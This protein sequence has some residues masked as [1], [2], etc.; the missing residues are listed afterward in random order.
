MRYANPSPYLSTVVSSGTNIRATNGSIRFYPTN[1]ATSVYK[2][3]RSVDTTMV[4][5]SIFNKIKFRSRINAVYEPPV[6]MVFGMRIVTNK[7]SLVLW[8]A[9]TSDPKA[10]YVVPRKVFNVTDIYNGDIND[11]VV[12]Y[13]EVYNDTGTDVE[14][15]Y[16]PDSVVRWSIDLP[17][18]I[19][20]SSQYLAPISYDTTNVPIQTNITVNSNQRV[21]WFVAS[22]PYMHEPDLDGFSIETQMQMSFQTEGRLVVSL[23]ANVD[24][25]I[26]IIGKSNTSQLTSFVYVDVRVAQ[27]PQLAPPAGEVVAVI[28]YIAF[29]Y[30]VRQ[31]APYTGQLTW[32]ISPT[33]A[34]LSIN[35]YGVIVIVPRKA[36][37]ETVTVTATNI[38]GVSSSVN[39][40]L[41]V[42]QQPSLVKIPEIRQ[43]IFDTTTIE[44]QETALDNRGALT[45][46]LTY[47]SPAISY[48]ANTGIITVQNNSF[49]DEVVTIKAINAAGGSNEH[50]FPMKIAQAPFINETS[51][52]I[53]NTEGLIYTKQLSQSAI[54]TG[55]LTWSLAT[56]QRGISISPNGLLTVSLANGYVTT[57]IVAVVSNTIGDAF[58][59]DSR[60]IQLRIGQKPI[61]SIPPPSAVTKSLA[62]GE[63]F[64]Y[65]MVNTAPSTGTLTWTLAR[66][67]TNLTLDPLTGVLYFP[68]SATNFVYETVQVTA[69]N[70][71]GLSTTI[72]FFVN[73]QKTPVFTAHPSIFS[74]NSDNGT[75]ELIRT[76]EKGTPTTVDF[77]QAVSNRASIDMQAAT[78]NISPRPV[79]I[80]LTNSVLTLFNDNFILQLMTLEVKNSAGGVG[81]I[82]FT[83]KVSQ[84]AEV[85]NPG[86]LVRSLTTSSFTHQ[87]RQSAVGTGPLEW[88]IMNAPNGVSINALTGLLTVAK[89]TFV[90]RVITVYTVDTN[91]GDLRLSIFYLLVAQTPSLVNPGAIVSIM[92]EGTPFTYPFKEAHFDDI[93]DN[94]GTGDGL[95][96]SI[97][98]YRSLTISNNGVITLGN[99]NNINDP[100]MTV[101]VMNRAGGMASVTFY[102]NIT[103]QVPLQSFD[104]IVYSM[105]YKTNFTLSLAGSI[106]GAAQ[107]SLTANPGQT[108]IP[109][110]V[111]TLSNSGLLTIQYN[112]YI[113]HRFVLTITQ[114]AAGESVVTTL[115]VYIL[116][117]QTPVLAFPYTIKRISLTNQQS[118][119][120]D[121]SALQRAS[122]TGPITW[123]IRPKISYMDL[124]PNGTLTISGDIDYVNASFTIY[125]INDAGG[126]SQPVLPF[127]I[128]HK[129][130]LSSAPVNIS[131]DTNGEYVMPQPLAVTPSASKTG[132]LVW[133]MAETVEGLFLD[134]EGKFHLAEGYNVENT[135]VTVTVA[136]LAGG[137]DTK[138]LNVTIVRTP[139]LQAPLNNILSIRAAE[140]TDFEYPITQLRSAV[141]TLTWSY[142]PLVNGL[143]I[144]PP[145]KPNKLVMEASKPVNQVIT[146]TATDA[147]GGSNS[148]TPF[149]LQKITPPSLSPIS[150]K[151]VTM[152]TSPVQF[153]ITEASGTAGVLY[154][155]ITEAP[156]ISLTPQSGT[157][158]AIVTFALNNYINQ[159]VK[160]LVANDLNESASALFRMQI[161]QFPQISNDPGTPITATFI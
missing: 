55:P 42:A 73:I 152:T 32:D 30:Q 139:I 83:L 5:M 35:R 104:R 160:V 74:I 158:N 145:G 40:P 133:T 62:V 117:A 29:K 141:G 31:L 103:Q 11:L 25:R 38:C 122:G 54:G 33:I 100:Y 18:Q 13:L 147:A 50:T 115:D 26:Y 3:V 114:E 79:S 19:V 1:T 144:S 87:M 129:P 142:T 57:S 107:W 27:N 94:E 14:Y 37:R 90:D 155:D 89:N 15:L 45:W 67:N 126:S 123:D 46:Q 36:I 121:I 63:N 120:F 143:Q 128:A 21:T 137:S 72:Q 6:M 28:E 76:L 47:A 20:V 61:I 106:A 52:I 156:G 78:W 44:I 7:G 153:T 99:F 95:V 108:A 112:N 101:G 88:Y 48:S 71:N 53:D 12:E 97:S 127:I 132:P 77:L 43:S 135:P 85:V 113:N 146:V 157:S 150:D 75:T 41:N 131:A 69:T 140:T 149:L 16:T 93:L 119:V 111:L 81:T 68:Y 17:P 124:Q 2:G 4:D 56:T 49:I 154:W 159:Q 51:L 64:T 105:L 118:S 148:T 98:A 92:V 130:I 91:T 86:S 23:G 138:V 66:V 24:G 134:Q 10:G 116:V 161:A 109:L 136:N 84:A 102:M 65:T 59:S 96:W 151:I 22:K 39:I 9:S 58:S 125:A 34:G 82:T 70:P 60:T 80:A 8:T 110:N